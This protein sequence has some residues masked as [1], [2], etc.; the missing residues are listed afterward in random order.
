MVQ[1]TVEAPLGTLPEL[2]VLAELIRRGLI[3]DVDFFSR[4]P[5]SGAGYRRADW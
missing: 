2:A 1:P 4:A 5:C 3:P